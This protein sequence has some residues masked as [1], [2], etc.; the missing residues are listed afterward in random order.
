MNRNEV[1]EFLGVSPKTVQRYVNEGKLKVVYVNGKGEYDN[2]EVLAFKQEKEMPVHRAIVAKGENLLSPQNQEELTEC[3][4]AIALYYRCRYLQQKMFLTISEAAIVSGLS[5]TGLRRAI[6][7]NN[8]RAVKLGGT[9]K[10][11]PQE[12]R[13][14]VDSCHI[15]LLSADIPQV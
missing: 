15:N 13:N 12:L 3:L 11:P 10:I 4:Q 9:W 14:Y 7:N 5:K 2:D 1:A 8:L 6:K